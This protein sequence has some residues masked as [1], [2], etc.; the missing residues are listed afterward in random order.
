VDHPSGAHPVQARVDRYSLVNDLGAVAHAVADLGSEQFEHL[1]GPDQPLPDT[2]SIS[3]LG[4]GTGLGVAQLVR[5]DGGYQVVGGEGG[6]IGFAPPTAWRTRSSS[7]AR[8]V[9][10][11]LSRA[12]GV[13]RGAR[14]HL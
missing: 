2:G 5:Y 13:G 14:Q 6:H 4:V 10:P 11:G 9:P 12:A 1:C 3:I 7:A 8:P